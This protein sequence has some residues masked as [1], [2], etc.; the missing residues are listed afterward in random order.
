LRLSRYGSGRAIQ[1]GPTRFGFEELRDNEK[2][3]FAM[4]LFRLQRYETLYSLR[5]G[6]RRSE[7]FL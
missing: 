4:K 7:M 2:G 3:D 5:C 6:S 1:D